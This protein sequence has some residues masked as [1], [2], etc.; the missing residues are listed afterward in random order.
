MQG[1]VALFTYTLQSICCFKVQ[2][3]MRSSVG[4]V[5]GFSHVDWRTFKSERRVG[6]AAGGMSFIDGDLVESFLDLPRTKME[7]VIV[8]LF[9]VSL[10]ASLPKFP[11]TP[12]FLLAAD[13]CSLWWASK[14]MARK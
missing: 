5:G 2:A 14:G 8:A 3:R 1:L 6:T 13:K 9:L 11:C 10:F 12:P 4:A 7:E